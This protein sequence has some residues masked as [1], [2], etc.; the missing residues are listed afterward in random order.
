[1]KNNQIYIKR[2]SLIFQDKDFI[3]ID[4]E[5]ENG[6][7]VTTQEPTGIRPRFFDQC[8]QFGVHDLVLEAMGGAFE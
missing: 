8:R 6:R 7:L 4:G 5:D 2:K 3:K 1:M